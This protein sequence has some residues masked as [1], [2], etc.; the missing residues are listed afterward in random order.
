MVFFFYSFPIFLY[1]CDRVSSFCFI[2]IGF[3]SKLVVNVLFM[4]NVGLV[5]LGIKSKSLLLSACLHAHTCCIGWDI[6]KTFLFN[7]TASLKITVIWWLHLCVKGEDTKSTSSM[8]RELN[9]AISSHI[10]LLCAFSLVNK[11]FTVH[12]FQ[13]SYNIHPWSDFNELI[14]KVMMFTVL[15][16]TLVKINFVYSQGFKQVILWPGEEIVT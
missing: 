12:Q 14:L 6:L 9:L 1:Q 16:Y 11:R 2:F 3:T 8:F 10:L 7:Q 4:E 13:L 5:V 15:K